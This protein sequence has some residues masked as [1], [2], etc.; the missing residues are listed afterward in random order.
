MPA[1]AVEEGGVEDLAFAAKPG[2]PV[3]VSEK[4]VMRMAVEAAEARASHNARQVTKLTEEL[5][6]TRVAYMRAEARIRALEEK[7]RH[8]QAR[9]ELLDSYCGRTGP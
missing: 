9:A 6:E 3:A 1:A 2:E 5:A 4:A 7:V 8:A